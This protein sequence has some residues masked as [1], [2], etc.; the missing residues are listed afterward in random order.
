MM[1]NLNVKDDASSSSSTTSNQV[2]SFRDVVRKGA[3]ILHLDPNP[4]ETT[5]H[6]SKRI[7]RRI[8]NALNKAGA[9]YK[10]TNMPTIAMPSMSPKVRKPGE[11]GRLVLAY[12]NAFFRDVVVPLGKNPGRVMTSIPDGTPKVTLLDSGTFSCLPGSMGFRV[13]RRTSE[14]SVERMGKQFM[15]VM[16]EQIP[17]YWSYM[18]PD[19]DSML[20][21]V[22]S[23]SLEYFA[24][25]NHITLPYSESVR[26]IQRVQSRTLLQAYLT[27]KMRMHKR[28]DGVINEYLL[29]HGTKTT[30]PDR[31][32]NGSNASGFDP[33]LGQGYYG[34]GAYFAE[35]LKYSYDGYSHHS[36]G[37]RQLFLAAVLTGKSKAYGSTQD[38][39]LRRAPELPNRRGLYDSVNGQ[40]DGTKMHVV[41][42]KTQSYPLYLIT[43]GTVNSS[44]RTTTTTKTKK[45]K[46][47]KQKRKTTKRKQCN[48][49][50]CRRARGM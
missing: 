7:A 10:A 28:N 5:K 43:F 39:Q 31:I 47:K 8:R 49:P 38:Q 15:S 33:R 37:N 34:Q 26:K 13:M 40:H 19:S 44:R 46:Y 45:R 30:N 36:R 48:C 25:K 42:E 22:E 21:D 9:D 20:V 18:R 41:Y 24:V 27:Q 1:K 12:A 29:F 32:W 35:E 16:T 6:S 50:S 14:M 3:C 2:T 11:S 17:S 4:T 23:N